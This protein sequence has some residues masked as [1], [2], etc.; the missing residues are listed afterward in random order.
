[1]KGMELPINTLI[2]VIIAI[3]VL[4]GVVAFFLG[5]WNPGTSGLQ[6]ETIKSSACQRLVSFGCS[7]PKD[8][9]IRDFDADKDG[10][11]DP[12]TG[13]NPGNP[14]STANQ[15]NLAALCWNYYFKDEGACKELCNCQ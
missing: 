12:G 14:S 15:D 8:V 2:I 7:E 3:I 11:L 6:L 9:V 1:M 5:V 10:G 13:W 4:I